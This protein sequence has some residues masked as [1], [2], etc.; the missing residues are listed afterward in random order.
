MAPVKFLTLGT[1]GYSQS[2][3]AESVP[4][5]ALWHCTR[6]HY[7]FWSILRVCKCMLASKSILKML[8]ALFRGGSYDRRT[9]KSD[10]DGARPQ[11]FAGQGCRAYSARDSL[12][13]WRD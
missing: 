7:V 3:H 8:A 9:C 10:S 6:S 2:N 11:K 5:T 13:R 1:S 4:Y 12:A